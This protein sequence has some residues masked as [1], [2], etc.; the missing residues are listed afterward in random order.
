M[1]KLFN[2]VLNMIGFTKLIKIEGKSDFN[3]L[4]PVEVSLM[5]D[6]FLGDGNQY[7]DP[8]AFNDFLHAKLSNENLKPIQRNLNDNAF[9]QKSGNKWPDINTAFLL[10]LSKKLKQRQ[11]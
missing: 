2:R 10:E 9:V 1:A 5:I 4:T 3:E 8:L 11:D 7:F 6:A